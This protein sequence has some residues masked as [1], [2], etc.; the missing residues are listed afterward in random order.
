MLQL[1]LQLVHH[2][3]SIS[4]DAPHFI[5]GDFNTCSLKKHLGHFY[6]Y[7]SCPTR[8]G[9]ILDLCYGT[10]KDAYKSFAM[11][12]LGFSDHSCVFSAS[13]YQSALK[14]D[15]VEC[16]EVS[17]WTYGAIKEL[18][19]C[20]HSTNWDVFKDSCTDLDELTFTVSSYI[21]F[22]EQMIIPTKTITLYPNNKPWVSRSLKHILNLKKKQLSNRM[23]YTKKKKL[24]GW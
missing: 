14:R 5:L 2:L 6:Q 4:P 15:K 22:C 13:I 21:R 17:V 12:P 16:R 24:K 7:V 3:Q 11:S 23:T 18:N 8:H 1:E 20:F 9:K 10:V 19:G